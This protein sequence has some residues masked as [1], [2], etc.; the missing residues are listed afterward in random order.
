MPHASIIIRTFNEEKHLPAL[1]D[2]LKMQ[3]YRDFETVVVDSGSFDFTCEIARQ[4]ADRL[5][6]IKPDDFTFG[7]SL[8]VG[9]RNSSGP[10]V[11]IISAHAVPSDADWLARIVTAFEDR[12]IAMVYGRQ[13]G[14]SDSKFSECLD[15][16]RTFGAERKILTPPNFFA[17]NANSAV[18]RDLWERHPFNE[19]LLGLEDIEWAKFWMER[20]Y[21]VVYEPSARVY[22]IHDEAWPQVRHR[23]YREGQAAKWM[24]ICRRRNIPRE[25][26]REFCYLFWDIR[27]ALSQRQL[28]QK[29][30]EIAR[31]R[32]EK[33]LGTVS[34][35]WDGARMENPLAR[36]KLLFDR[37]YQAVVIHAPG[38][39]SLVQV[40]LPTLKPS[41]VLVRVAYQGV[42]ATDVEIFDG[43]LGYYK[44][45]LAQYPIVPGHE[46]SG[47]VAAVG[48]RV[49][50]LRE[51]DRVVV[52]C[53]QGCGECP[54]CQR[55]NSINCVDRREVGVI[56]RDGGYAE[57]MVTP[58]RFV[59]R[60]PDSVSL[61]DACLC[62]PLAVV[63]KGLKRL[64]RAWG[65]AAGSRTCV[66][67]GG[68]PIGH[69]AAQMLAQRGH[70]VTVYD[71]DAYRLAY[72]SGSMIKTTQDLRALVTFDAVV[73]ATGDPDVLDTILR[74][75]AAGATILLLG[76]PY[77]KRDFSF[78]T[79]VGY[80]KT[81]IGSVG[82]TERDFEE[83]VT[84]LPQIDTKAFMEKMLPL[85]EFAQAW[86][87]CRAR[88]SLKVILQID[89]SDRHS[90]IE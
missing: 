86:D 88:K 42:C 13:V 1:F 80:D 36:E 16:E 57:Y 23:Y 53:I 34:G 85:S 90:G 5:V 75:S 64:E 29:G 69:L 44:T 24:G 32:V 2:G 41:E 26:W 84:A 43:A 73:E 33:L 78:E 46:F 56:G 30:S 87:I 20:S 76:L 65:S 38:C 3:T 74:A 51:G 47:T 40:Q 27:H 58:R 52:E 7:Y 18:R 25:A 82:S 60:L 67:T 45:G 15:F 54:A 22:H 61:Q 50:D 10:L 21:D 17:N 81:V 89:S 37:H 62:E 59:H 9:V 12:R 68:G 48:S 6:R 35:I 8:N 14:G 11:V 4:R 63:L 28:G 49:A 72:F 55:S 71:G 19:T 77:A 83:A 31:F 66:V 39:A 79:I 70:Q